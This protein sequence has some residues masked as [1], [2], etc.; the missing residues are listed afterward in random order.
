MAVRL[1][2]AEAAN[3]ERPAAVAA[4]AERRGRGIAVHDLDALDR[5]AELVRHDL[6]EGRLVALAVA[7]RAG[8][9]RHVARRVELDLGR[10]PLP[11]TATQL[12]VDPRRSQAACLV[13][14]RD[15]D[16]A[17]LAARLD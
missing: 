9:H 13:A 12:A 8:K 10:L 7:V 5:H 14:G 17:E 1:N 4:H 2:E 11:D 16:A 15:A 6:G 3:R